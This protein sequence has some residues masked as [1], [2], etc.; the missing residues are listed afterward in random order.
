VEEALNLNISWFGDVFKTVTFKKCFM[1]FVGF[2]RA[3]VKFCF[4][5]E[6]SSSLDII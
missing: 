4:L 3:Y 5:E 2:G 1:N 6:V